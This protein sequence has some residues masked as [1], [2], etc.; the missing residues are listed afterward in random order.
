MAKFYH[1]LSS[2]QRCQIYTLRKSGKSQA[3]IASEIG[4]DP[5]TVSRELSRNKGKRNYGFVQAH[6]KATER[7][8]AANSLAYRMTA[9]VQEFIIEQLQATQSSPIQISG[10]MTEIGMES[11]SHE[12]I[13]RM[14]AKD[15]KQGGDLHKHLRRRGKKYNKPEYRLRKTLKVLV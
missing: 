6:K 10:R 1:Q 12:S 14:I 13:Y 7:R 15:K 2:D 5:S 8:S 4:V 3:S 9:D 11:V